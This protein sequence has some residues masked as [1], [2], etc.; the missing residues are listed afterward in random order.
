MG[1][2]FAHAGGDALRV[3]FLAQFLFVSPA[4]SLMSGGTPGLDGDVTR[5]VGAALGPLAT[6]DEIKRSNL[7]GR[8]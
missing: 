6:I 3:I 8:G 1:H 2:G 5:A 7:R 4:S